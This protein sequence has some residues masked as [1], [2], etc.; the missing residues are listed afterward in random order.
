MDEKLS[1]GIRLKQ[2][3]TQK[4]F[5]QQ[6]VADQLGVDRITYAN[7]EKGK[8]IP[9]FDL[10]VRFAKLTQTPLD[11]FAGNKSE[12]SDFIS[13]T[14]SIE[15]RDEVENAIDVDSLRKQA[16]LLVEENES[17]KKEIEELRSDL[18]KVIRDLR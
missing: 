14:T 8:T 1:L 15:L 18:V 3:R 17:L 5:S 11:Y 4:G 7:Y 6:H 2:L 13:R 9:L 10:V 16:L 12:S